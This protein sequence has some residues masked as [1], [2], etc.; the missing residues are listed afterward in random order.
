MD[1]T[2]IQPTTTA[3]IT[4]KTLTVTGITASNKPYDGTTTASLTTSGATLQGVVAGDSGGLPNGNISLVTGLATGAFASPDAGN[5]ITVQVSGLTLTGGTKDGTFATVDYVLTEPTTTANITKVTLTV[6]GITANNKTYDGTTTASLTTSGATLN[7]LISGDATPPGPGSVSLVTT[8][9]SGAFTSIDVANGITV[10]VAGL[11]LAGTTKDGTAATTDY[12]LTQP[13]TAANITPATLTVTGITA[14]KTYDGTT[15]ATLTTSSAMLNGVVSGDA[16]PPGPGSV[17]LV[18]TGATGTY[19]TPGAGTLIAVQVAGLTLTGTTKD[20]TSAN[21]DYTL[22]QPAITGTIT[23]AF[24]TPVITANNKPAD[25]TTTAT[26]SS[27]YVTGVILPDTSPGTVNLN[28]TAANFSNPTT[29]IWTVTA[30][31]L[32]LSGTGAGNY[33]LNSTTATAMATITAGAISHFLVSAPPVVSSGSLFI[34]TVTAEDLYNNTATSYTG[35]LTFSSSDLNA[36]VML[37]AESFVNNGVGYFLASLTT[38]T[39]GLQTISATDVTTHSIT[40]MSNQILVNPVAGAATHFTVS[41]PAAVSAGSAFV[42]TVTALDGN[43][44]VATSYSGTV[45]FSSNDSQAGLSGDATLINGVGVGYFAEVL[46]TAGTQ[47]ITATDTVTHGITGSTTVSVNPLAATHFSVTAASVAGPAFATT[48]TGFNFTVT[49]LDTYGNLATAYGGTVTFSSSTDSLATFTPT[50][51][52]LTGG[53]GIFSATL[54]TAGSN[55]ITA[56]D[57]GGV[58]GTSA[59]IA[60]RGLIVT[61][62]TGSATGF[63]VTFNKAYDPTTLSLYYNT[64]DVILTSPAGKKIVGSL[65]ANSNNTGFTF[66]KTGVGTSGVLPVSG[67]YTVTILSGGLKDLAGELLDGANS[68]NV[69]G[70]TYTGTFV[71]AAVPTVILGIPDFARGPDTGVQVN[72]PQSINGV[73]NTSGIPITLTSAGGATSVTF[74]LAYSTSLL[75]IPFTNA[76]AEING[77]TGTFKLT[78]APSGGVASFQWTGPALASGT[79]TLGG[80]VASVPNSAASIYKAKQLLTLSSIVT[81][82][83]VAVTADGGLDVNAYLGDVE[84]VGAYGGGDAALLDRVALSLDTGFAAFPQLDPLI[85]G[86]LDG[87]TTGV[88]STDVTIINLENVGEGPAQVPPTAGLPL[89]AFT[90]AGPDPA[91]SVGN[92]QAAAGGTVVVP[93]NID[94]ARPADST[95]MINAVLA[96]T[97]NPQVFTVSPADV[98]LGSLPDGGS[99]WQL[100]S[101]INPKTGEIGIDLF[102]MT[103][104]DTT[105]GGSLVTITLH[106]RDTAPAGATALQLVNEVDPAGQRVFQTMVGEAQGAYVLHPAATAS[107]V[108]PGQPGFITVSGA[109][110]AFDTGLLG[111]ALT[112]T[113]VASGLTAAADE[114][115]GQMPQTTASSTLPIAHLPLVEQVLAD[116]GQTGQ[117]IQDNLL[118]Q[119][120][121]V[122]DVDSGDGLA[123]GSRSLP[124]TQLTAMDW[125]S[126]D[127]AAYLGNAARQGARALQLLH[128]LA[129]DLQDDDLAGLEAFFAREAQGGN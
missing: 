52:T 19:A 74:Q 61:G 91:L 56:T 18:T 72:V 45:H 112:Q 101:A 76:G 30:T 71:L 109:M 40:N 83:S 63:A 9:A 22:T 110:P 53:Q 36:G 6:S 93:V 62:L 126:D 16:T 31:G 116:L 75:T 89:T 17:S 102:S 122:L 42:V 34:F 119:P 12:A 26:L 41:A 87:S 38:T 78:A 24:V 118:G 39:P 25:G 28:V 96:L 14:S 125:A 94:T 95:G 46:K 23:K 107:G 10:N 77:A 15:T 20:G 108:E 117:A 106:V 32:S 86:G 114:V 54:N 60:T 115:F 21:T 124:M 84:G 129:A 51:H 73:P 104:I 64:A 103:P 70:S 79:V 2:L 5:G 37:P 68:G 13:A 1:Y 92:A 88:D 69:A 29:G 48:G 120:G 90:A 33:Q 58:T 66:V 4:P 111:A 44:L 65:V 105:L 113:P 82:P 67:T 127:L 59:A 100:V 50:S 123:G 3:T 8:A 121:A 35:P 85:I 43:N 47:T 81:S 57:T 27:Q 55:T 7:G 128:G 98:Q 80:I 97:Y 11:T 49:A 99:G